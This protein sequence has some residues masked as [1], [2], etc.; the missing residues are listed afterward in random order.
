MPQR[1]INDL[2]AKKPP[3]R[4]RMSVLLQSKEP[5]LHHKPKSGNSPNFVDKKRGWTPRAK[6]RRQSSPPPAFL[7]PAETE[8]LMDSIT[9]P[10]DRAIFSLAYHRGL[11]AS[12]IGM[13]EMRD[14]IAPTANERVGTL[15]C[16]RLKDSYS[17][18]YSLTKSEEK[19]LRAWLR[20]R[21]KQP[22]L[23]FASR[24]HTPNR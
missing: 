19:E 22:G 10:R 7:T 2:K 4:N 15:Y 23:I 16:R 13:I 14:Y 9:N 21:S 24:Q 1:R 20:V 12:E 5:P 17:K 18:I 11:R 8:R 6:V 3:Q